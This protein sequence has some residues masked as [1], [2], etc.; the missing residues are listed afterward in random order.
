[1]YDKSALEAKTVRELKEI[2]T[3][4][5]LKFR[6]KEVKPNLIAAIISAQRSSSRSGSASKPAAN[7]ASSKPLSSVQATLESEKE[8][9][10]YT[11]TILV[12]CGASTGNFPVVGKRISE[13]ASF[14]KD[15]LNISIDSQP[16]VNGNEVSESYILGNKDVLEF[17]AKAGRKG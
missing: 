7:V 14:L 6:S 3:D 4:L 15:A 17:V 13:V 5:K 2:A 9:G 1:M 16:L 11:N 10:R 12:S 8:G